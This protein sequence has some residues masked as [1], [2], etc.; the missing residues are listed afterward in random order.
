MQRRFKVFPEGFPAAAGACAGMATERRRPG[1]NKRFVRPG[2]R[3]H[4]SAQRSKQTP[5]HCGGWLR[6]R[7]D[8]GRLQSMNAKE[9][10]MTVKREDLVAAAA[11]GLLPCT[12]IDPMLIFLLQRDVQLQR[13]AMLSQQ[14]AGRVRSRHVLLYLTAIL[15]IAAA[16]FAAA[17]YARLAFNALGAAGLL[18]FI[19]LYA[20]FT[21]GLAAWF[22]RRRVG[23]AARIFATSAVALV[24]LAAFA[25]QQLRLF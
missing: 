20:L 13:K 19:A 5:S 24:P 10:R 6:E 1:L 25:A 15:A 22:E 11:A 7:G 12:Q 14:S 17:F 2:A 8:R 9:R 23:M 18:W 3:R 16:T 21:I 4:R